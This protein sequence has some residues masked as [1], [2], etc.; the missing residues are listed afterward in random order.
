MNQNS[1]ISYDTISLSSLF[2]VVPSFYILMNKG[3]L[4]F[5]PLKHRFRL[6]TFRL[7]TLRLNTFR[8]SHL[9]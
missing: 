2:F 7:N 3:R 6:N 4:N 9:A 1:N 8:L 5:F